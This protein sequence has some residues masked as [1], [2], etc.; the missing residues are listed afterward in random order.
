[1]HT[2]NILALAA[3]VAPI[4][5]K[6]DLT[7]CTSS[8]AGPKLIWYVPDTGELCEFLDCGGGRAPPKTTVPGC[9]QYS[10]TATYS[11]NYLPGYGPGV[12]PTPTPSSKAA[13][14][15]VTTTPPPSVSS[16]Y[17]PGKTVIES[18]SVNV[19]DL[20]GK[21]VIESVS[22]TTTATSNSSSTSSVSRAAGAM[23]TV[24][25]VGMVVGGLA[26]GAAAMM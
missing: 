20:P 18:S 5:A 4:A 8:V 24:G 1:M 15:A 13:G 19:S 21:T 17:L 11:P 25:V 23:P 7:G 16:S 3:L 9:A 2:L 22:T 14:S 26:A 12:T 6:T 10:G